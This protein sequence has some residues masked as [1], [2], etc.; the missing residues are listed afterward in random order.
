MDENKLRF[1]VG[2]LV[3]SAIG[4]GIILTFLFGA[5]PSVLSQNYT[6]RV[7]FP[8]AEG[9]SVNT[10]VVRDGVRIGRV[11]DI[12]LHPESGVLVTLEMQEAYR[13]KLTH[14]YIPQIGTGNLV[15]GDSQ[16]QF[17]VGS[18]SELEKNWGDNLEILDEPYSEIEETIDY[19]KVTTSLFEMQDDLV[20]AFD[21]MQVAGDAI[22]TAS[23][24]INELAIEMRQTIGG[25]DTKVNEVADQAVETLEEF[26]GTLRDIRAIVGDPEIRQNL[27]DSLKEMPELLRN[28]Q[29]TLDGVQETF[30]TFDSVGVQFE[31]VG[32][33]AEKAVDSFQGTVENIEQ[34]TEPLAEN[35]DQ[36]VTQILQTL[37]TL[38]RA[39]VQVDTFGRTLNNSDGSLKR[40]LED[41]EI[42][43]ELRRTIQNIEEASAK[44]RPILD[45]VRI[46][47]DKVARDPREL[48]VKG[49]L[50]RRPSGA[51]LK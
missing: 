23:G 38:D 21:S 17:V 1:G 34:F 2:V 11:S 31:R 43:W 9:I 46:F 18:P 45:D 16:I 47:T 10:N 27:E 33:S 22:A 14:R 49:A 28:A 25:T 6:L 35:G 12:Q 36:L 8:S 51:G 32:V 44:V 13:N 40:F 19:G 41:D 3:I 39:L 4:I 20:Q 30:E 37:T 15:S 42:Y 5:F 24:S 29:T 50:S 26:Q 7:R 48:G